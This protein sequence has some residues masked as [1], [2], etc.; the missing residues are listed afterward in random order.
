MVVGTRAQQTAAG[1]TAIDDGTT[2]LAG[3]TL[4]AMT[5]V[6][7]RATTGQAEPALRELKALE[8]V[9]IDADADWVEIDATGRG[10]SKLP[11]ARIEAIGMAAVMGLASRPVLVI[12]FVLNWST[13]IGSPMKVLRL[14]SDRFDPNLFAPGASTPLEALRAWIAELQIA[15]GAACLPTRELLEGR[16]AR[17]ESLEAYEREVLRATPQG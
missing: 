17:F 3:Q 2:A 7:P 15:S 1:M 14:R 10:K 11:L 16:Y 9:P 5:V 13:D 4:E 8:A 6:T 12:D